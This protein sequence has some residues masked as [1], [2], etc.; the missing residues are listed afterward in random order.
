MLWV[1]PLSNTAMVT[2]LFLAWA[3]SDGQATML[4]SPLT[5]N[6]STVVPTPYE[7]WSSSAQSAVLPLYLIFSI[8]WGLE[9]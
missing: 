9:M 5:P 2:L 4:T 3:V 7:L 1:S 6:Y 8:A